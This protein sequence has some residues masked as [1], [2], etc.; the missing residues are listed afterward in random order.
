RASFDAGKQVA[1]ACQGV[2]QNLHTAFTQ[3]GG[4]PEFVRLATGD[5]EKYPIIVFKLANGRDANVT[6]TG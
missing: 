6:Q 4:R 5:P 3:L 1:G 2:A